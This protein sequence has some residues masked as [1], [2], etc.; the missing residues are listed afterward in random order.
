[1]LAKNNIVQGGTVSDVLENVPS[2]SL[3]ID[4]NIEL[5]GN[6]NVRILLMENPQDSSALVELMH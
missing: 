6:N 1:M 5:R 2:V 4:G 3:D